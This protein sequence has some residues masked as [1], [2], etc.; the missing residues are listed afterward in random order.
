MP[1]S[2]VSLESLS[3]PSPSPPPQEDQQEQEQHS[4]HSGAGLDSGSELSELTEEEQDN[5]GANEDDA[6]RSAARKKRQRDRVVPPPMWDWAMKKK[7]DK[8]DRPDWRSKFE[9]EEEE[10]EQAGPAEAMEEEEED[11]QARDLGSDPVLTPDHEEG[12]LSDN[13]VDDNEH[14][15]EPPEDEGEGEGE[16]EVE[17]ESA[18]EAPPPMDGDVANGDGDVSADEVDDPENLDLDPDALDVQ[19]S[20]KLVASP[21][22]TDDEID[23]EPENDENIGEDDVED[24]DVPDTGDV[25][26]EGSEI[27]EEEEETPADDVEIP[28]DE[29]P[30]TEAVTPAEGIADAVDADLDATM[31]VDTVQPVLMS[32]VAVAASS[33]MAGAA[34]LVSPSSSQPSTPSG[35][36]HSSRYPSVE[37]E[38]EQDVPSEPE[39]EPEPERK[40]SGR[41]ARNR[42]GKGRTRAA[43]RSRAA[44]AAEGDADLDTPHAELP[45]GEGVD[46]EDLDV[47]TPELDLDADMQPAHRAEALDVL[48]GIELKFALL[49][50]RLYVEKMDS[51]AW[52]EGLIADGTHP[53]LLH[54][55][56]ELSSR[57]D[58]R[59]ELAARRRDYE[60]ANVAK[61]RRLD[62]SGAW[63]TWSN[64]RDRLQSE[65]VAETNGKK[66]KLE[67]ERRTLERPQPVRRY[68]LPLHD[69][70][71]ALSLR[72]IVKSSPF[73]LPEST[74]SL[75][76][77]ASRKKESAPQVPL[78]YP[79]L[80]P[81]S[82]GEIMHDFDLFHS[83]RHVPMG[84]DPHRGMPGLM[85]AVLGGVPHGVDPYAMGMQVM[86]GPNRLGP[87]M[88]HPHM[89][90]FA[91][92]RLPHQ[93]SA[94]PGAPPH[95]SHHQLQMEQE[96][97]MR[98]APGIPHPHMQQFAGGPVN[99][100]GM[101][102]RR[103]ISPVPLNGA[104]P[105]P[106]V[107]T[108]LG[109]G[110]IPPAFPNP[111][112]NGWTGPGKDSK[113]LNGESEGRDRERMADVLSQREKE[114]IE[115]ERALRDLDREREQEAERAYRMSSHVP[116]RHSAHQHS[117]PHVHNTQGPAAHH[118]G[119][120]SHQHQH[121]HHHVHHHHHGPNQGF[122]GP[123]SG[124][125]PPMAGLPPNTG[126]GSAVQTLSPRGGRDFEQRRPRSGA[127]T[128]VIELSVAPQ[129]QPANSPPMSAFWKGEPPPPGQM[130]PSDRERERE[131]ERDRERAP[132]G[133]L[134]PPQPDVH[135][136]LMTPF[137]MGPS[138]IQRDPSLTGSPRKLHGPA[139]ASNPT[140]SVPSSRRGSWSADDHPRPSSAVLGV[141][142]AGPSIAPGSQ[143]L[144]GSRLPPAPS[145]SSYH[146]AF[147][148]PPHSN[149]RVLPHPSSPS[150]FAGPLRSPVRSSQPG[151]MPLG[152]PLSPPPGMPLSPHGVGS[153]GVKHPRAPS[154]GL[155]KPLPK[156]GGF[157]IPETGN[158]VLPNGA[159]HPSSSSSS[160]PPTLPPPPTTL[161][162]PRIPN[163]A[164]VEKVVGA[165]PT[166]A[167]PV[168]GS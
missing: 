144:G 23:H 73:G 91:P 61:R 115:R 53:E 49:R 6:S 59:L 22:L 134:G 87:P 136:R 33:I 52:E 66:R 104:G 128:E 31:D 78:A 15:E 24:D 58:K 126:A 43:R 111:K 39:V 29:P 85:N 70:P 107:P 68:P 30:T 84:Y 102:M 158:Y 19:Q 94:P 119:P 130:L 71:P 151:R 47:A 163:G 161:P 106:S 116:S 83:H 138:Q 143:R 69:V 63:S 89:Q 79:T 88:Q 92:Q 157:P 123:G 162:P 62:E 74:S 18:D 146:G 148:S 114:R 8:K 166:K 21:D 28:A 142:P 153:P 35:S 14:E 167:V 98:Q 95:I 140:Q 38:P 54:L 132:P 121:H 13:E 147:G 80:A 117:H 2:T 27:D 75:A 127:P 139:G 60:A 17:G 93:H 3:S 100:L 5:D 48:A 26:K 145:T 152:G 155:T 120:H 55:Q 99:G 77:R 32:P 72:D 34:L 57:R 96:M 36:R 149:G 25:T 56:A 165:P 164:L 20:P 64:D 154:P 103:S 122:S 51:L 97:Q 76:K 1:G 46:G 7:A 40:P 133:P 118:H 135:D 105:G 81:L 109:G 137:A 112:T 44:L 110:P 108:T 37:P 90:G 82:R 150:A 45:D 50:E 11:D 41:A 4:N 113:R 129:K 42:K 9:E 10:E 124:H 131:R 160:G 86:D 65:M 16:G 159:L 156:L 101:L 168:D 12:A 125:A 141:G 67:R